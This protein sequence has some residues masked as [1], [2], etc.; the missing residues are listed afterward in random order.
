MASSA[1]VFECCQ[2]E[3]PLELF[4]GAFGFHVVDGLDPA[5][6]V[7]V[8]VDGVGLIVFV[9][10]FLALSNYVLQRMRSF[11][12]SNPPTVKFK[13][14]QENDEKGK[15]AI[16]RL[17]K[18]CLPHDD[19]LDPDEGWW[20]IGYDG[21]FPVAFCGMK[22][23]KRFS[24]GVY[25]SRSG[26]TYYYRGHGLQKK[27]LRIRDRFAKNNGYEWAFS[28]TTDNPASANSLIACGYKL[29]DPSIAYGLDT[30]IYW[31]KLLVEG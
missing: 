19:P 15:N 5:D 30:T 16:V 29:Y 2:P 12:H 22:E 11:N 20:W 24:N 10:C 9:I 23:S 31:R 14:L 7:M 28:D 4:G 17:Q 1:K 13:R 3:I 18:I 6:L 8:G 21:E 26:V 25:M 27:M